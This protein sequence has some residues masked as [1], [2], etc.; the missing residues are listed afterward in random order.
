MEND[1]T[2][3]EFNKFLELWTVYCLEVQKLE[4]DINKNIQKRSVNAGVRVRK[5][6]RILNRLA[7]EMSAMSLKR[8]KEISKERKQKKLDQ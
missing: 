7:K 2:N 5:G 6:L 8:D 3:F 1:E 4:N